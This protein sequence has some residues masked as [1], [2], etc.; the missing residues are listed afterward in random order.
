MRAPVILFIALALAAQAET[1]HLKNGRT[2]LASNVREKNGR[3]EWEVGDNTYSINKSLVERID[4]GGAPVVSRGSAAEEIE[5]APPTERV[6][7]AEELSGRVVVQGK[8][9][10]GALAAV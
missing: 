1:I 2:I 8:V 6:E 10:P 7:H 5:V 3:I 4:T 9:D